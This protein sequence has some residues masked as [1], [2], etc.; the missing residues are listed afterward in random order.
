ML[1]IKLTVDGEDAKLRDTNLYKAANTADV[2]LGS[3]NFAKEFGVDKK[4]FMDSEFNISS[5]SYASHVME[6]LAQQ[7][8]P[9]SIA[10]QFASPLLDTVAVSVERTS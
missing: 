10:L 9:A 3:L 2:Q 4:F 7:G 1:D 8:I 5:A 6:R